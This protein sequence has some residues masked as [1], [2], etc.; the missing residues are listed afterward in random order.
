MRAVERCLDLIAA[1]SHS[2]PVGFEEL[3]R[4]TGL[5]K[6]S[7]ARLLAVLARRAVVMKDDGD[8]RW[9]LG[10]G[11]RRLSGLDAPAW[12]ARRYLAA[13]AAPVVRDLARSGWSAM[14]VRLEGDCFVCV[15]CQR[16]EGGLPFLPVG[17]SRSNLGDW[18]WGR[19][20]RHRRDGPE[21]DVTADRARIGVR[22][23]GQD[24]ALCLGRH[25]NV[26]SAAVTAA[27]QALA[28]AARRLA[29]ADGQLRPASTSP[30][31]SRRAAGASPRRR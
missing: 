24:A 9:Q 4:A 8:G 21:A 13:A 16:V 15:A 3:R 2:G 20:L 29:D 18:P 23:P 28:L 31:G 30:T 7:L 27:A 22:I 19:L 17:K 6:P 1:L 26:A 25:G 14:C 12:A 5:S 10:E 11:W